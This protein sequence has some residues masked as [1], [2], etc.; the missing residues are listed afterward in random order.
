VLLSDATFIG[1]VRPFE[2]GD[3]GLVYESLARQIVQSV[4]NGDFAHALEGGEAVFYYG[5]PGLRY[6]RAA[7]HLVFGD[8]F[9]GY[10]SLILFLPFVVF[11]IFRRFFDARGALAFALVFLAIPIGAVFG[12][13]FFQYVKWAVRGF[14]DPA[15]A[16]VFLGG[17]VVLIGRTAMGPGPRF[18]PAFGAGL[19]FALAL[20]VRPNLAP[21]AGVLLTGAGLAALWQGQFKRVAG[22]CLGFLPVFG[23]ALHNWVFGHVFVLF[24]AN[25]SIPEALPMPPQDYVAALGELLRLDV[26]GEHVRRG[27]LQ[28]GRWLSGPSESFLMVPFHAAAFLV[29]I[30][31]ALFGR[32]FDP[33]LRLTA[34]AMLAQHPVAWFYLSYGRYYY[35]A[36]LLT[37]LVCA[38]WT[39]D[40][41]LGRFRVAWPRAADALARNPAWTWLAHVLD[42]WTKVTGV[43]AAGPH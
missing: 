42:W 31:V 37:F 28:V 17:L 5:G 27:M 1:G 15:A 23:M 29:L 35:L 33:W 19:L 12:T 10:L 20:W 11:A 39:R 26:A 7:E 16:A 8:T 4:I 40:E 38:V 32:R 13:T 9:L 18:A 14:A 2:G 43:A 41:G 3:D 6:L 21:G 25:A 36:W 34:G 30:R 22:L 24:S